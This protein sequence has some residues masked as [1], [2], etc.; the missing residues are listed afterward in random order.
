MGKEWVSW[1]MVLISRPS[2]TLS[3]SLDGRSHQVP[4]GCKSRE[5]DTK[6]KR[7]ERMAQAADKL[8]GQQVSSNCRDLFPFSREEEGKKIVD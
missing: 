2:F 3:L 8:S 1:R 7:I 6:Y 4:R 5:A